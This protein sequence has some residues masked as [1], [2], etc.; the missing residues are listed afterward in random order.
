MTI[1]AESNRSMWRLMSPISTLSVD[2]TELS[3]SIDLLQKYD[4]LLIHWGK[5]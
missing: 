4:I 5:K 2:G 1:Q 3:H